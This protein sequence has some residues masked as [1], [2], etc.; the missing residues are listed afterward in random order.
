MKSDDLIFLKAGT[1][2]LN[3][4]G[5]L[6]WDNYTSRDSFEY[7]LGKEIFDSIVKKFSLMNV[8]AGFGNDEVVY[9]GKNST[10]PRFK[11][12]EFFLQN[13][14]IKTKLPETAQ[15][16]LLNKKTTENL[17]FSSLI[18]T[19]IP[20][21]KEIVAK[22]AKRKVLFSSHSDVANLIKEK[23]LN[24]AGV[25]IFVI[26]VPNDNQNLRRIFSLLDINTIIPI[27]PL[28]FWVASF[29]GK[30]KELSNLKNI[31][32]IVQNENA[33]IVFDEETI[34]E[35][36][37]KNHE[38]EGD[39]Y[40]M[41]ESLLQSGI[42]DNINMGLDILANS[43]YSESL[44]DIVLILNRNQKYF[45]KGRGEITYSN[46]FKRLNK[47]ISDQKKLKWKVAW[48]YCVNIILASGNFENQKDKIKSYIIENL[49]KD[50]DQYISNSVRIKNIILDL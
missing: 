42:N 41:V 38:I 2:S 46:N 37:E 22:Y 45:V 1:L 24:D 18:K 7:I 33:N 44:L 28:D 50:I 35:V 48:Q 39:V 9:I 11:L 26:S 27:I 43:R 30:D 14:L 49:Q 6:V 15:T 19:Y 17:L 34:E 31:Y 32:D 4:A 8:K 10:T 47:Y 25:D 29:W 20:I 12:K 13:R 5:N 3:K 23:E 36:H 40:E 21:S 16:I